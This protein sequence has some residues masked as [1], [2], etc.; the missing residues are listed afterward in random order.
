[1]KRLAAC[2]LRVAPFLLATI[3]GACTGARVDPPLSPEPRLEAT[4]DA[5]GEELARLRLQLDSVTTSGDSLR[6]ELARLQRE[7]QRLKDIDLRR[8]N[9]RG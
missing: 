3:I 9:G 5:L 4:I 2:G 8:K 6:S 7:L 1:M